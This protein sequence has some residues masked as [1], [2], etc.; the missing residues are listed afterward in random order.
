MPAEDSSNIQEVT[1]YVTEILDADYK[2]GRY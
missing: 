1:I 2:K